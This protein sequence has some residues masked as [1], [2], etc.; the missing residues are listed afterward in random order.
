MRRLRDAA[1]N[2]TVGTLLGKAPPW[3]RACEELKMLE[4]LSP[5]SSSTFMASTMR[6]SHTWEIATTPRDLLHIGNNRRRDVMTE[7]Q[8]VLRV[9]GPMLRK[10][11][12]YSPGHAT[13]TL[14]K[15][16]QEEDGGMKMASYEQSYPPQG[17]AQPPLPPRPPQGSYGHYGHGAQAP[18]MNFQQGVPYSSG[19]RPYQQPYPGH[20]QRLM[21]S[22][23]NAMV[24]RRWALGAGTLGA[25]VALLSASQ[26]LSL[27]LMEDHRPTPKPQL[28]VARARL[29]RARSRVQAEGK[30]NSLSG[31][32]R[33]TELWQLE[34]A[35]RARPFEADAVLRT[36]QAG[37]VTRAVRWLETLLSR[38]FLDTDS[39][40]HCFGAIAV[41]FARQGNAGGA[42]RYVQ[43]IQTAGRRPEAEVFQ[44]SILALAEGE[45]PDPGKT[46]T[47]LVLLQQMCR[48]GHAPDLDCCKAIL[49]SLGGPER[50][51]SP[52]SL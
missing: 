28:R 22:P 48:A 43:R 11:Q 8:Q 14:A 25:T 35:P 10:L 12:K 51:A 3:S 13:R 36:A 38:G 4:T 30:A 47:T 41:S 37:D 15:T 46:E 18:T 6:T 40:D 19:H 49:R 20:N 24:V 44:E 26:R 27:A 5:L 50:S 32:L 16:L 34:A 29:L 45:D 2:D 21:D 7:F 42:L 17:Q 33:S 9:Q 31:A 52:L 23:F 1:L 39:M